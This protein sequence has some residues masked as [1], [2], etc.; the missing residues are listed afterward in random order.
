V[1]PSRIDLMRVT[2]P[3]V[4]AGRRAAGDGPPLPIEI[5]DVHWSR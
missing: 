4:I 1:G 3:F 5:D 2:A